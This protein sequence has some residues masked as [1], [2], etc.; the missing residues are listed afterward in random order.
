MLETNAKSYD[1]DV[2][3]DDLSPEI[4]FDDPTNNLSQETL[5]NSSLLLRMSKRQI[6]RVLLSQLF[7]LTVDFRNV[8]QLF[9]TSC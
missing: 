5:V 1:F 9:Q 6:V 3:W 8:K 4:V 2:S 7:L